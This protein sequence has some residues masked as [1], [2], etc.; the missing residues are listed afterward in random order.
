MR[1]PRRCA[2]RARTAAAGCGAYSAA[3]VSATRQARRDGPH[4]RR[5]LADEIIVT[6]DNPRREDPRA[7]V[8]AIMRRA[9][10]TAGGAARS[11]VIHDRA[12]AIRSALA[13]AAAR[14]CGAGGRQGS[15]GLPDHRQRAARR[16]A[17]RRVRLARARSARS[18]AAHHDPHAA[19]IRRRLRRPPA[20]G[21]IAPS[22]RS[23][24]TRRKLAA[25][26][27]F[28]ALR[29]E[30]ADGHEFV[31]R[32][33]GRGAAGALVAHAARAAAAADRGVQRRSGARRCRRARARA[34]FSGP[35][36]GVA[37]SN[38]KTTVK[39]MI[40]AILSQRG[41]CLCDARQSQQSPRRADDAAAPDDR[42]L[43]RGDRDG[44]E[45]RAA[46]SRSWCRWRGPTS[47]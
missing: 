11:R 34:Q 5:A 1:W 45:P 40:A 43:Q 42:A 7:I 46:T 9:S 33:R 22:T 24:S 2:R 4:R 44:S 18:Q 26:D 20:S 23:R 39:E 14:R 38:G 35:V 16:S 3:A 10:R 30:Q 28:A 27:L 19:A 6:D 13:T 47:G 8:A 15:R 12:P 41:P 17:I 36:V 21:R 31:R 29:G 32:G 25:G 37:G